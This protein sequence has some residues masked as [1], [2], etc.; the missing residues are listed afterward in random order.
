MKI[1]ARTT[2]GPF[3][4]ASIIPPMLALKIKTFQENQ[5]KGAD[6]NKAKLSEEKLQK[7]FSKLELC[8]LDN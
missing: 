4:I 2:T 7:L 3:N 6:A 1:P 8:G 5:R